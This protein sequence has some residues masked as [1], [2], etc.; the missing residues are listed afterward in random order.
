[1]DNG[2]SSNNDINQQINVENRTFK[3][4]SCNNLVNVTK[5]VGVASS[6]VNDYSN[7]LR[8]LNHD[9]F[10]S[11]L[12]SSQT[13]MKLSMFIECMST[14]TDNKFSTHA[15]EIAQKIGS[16]RNSTFEKCDPQIQKTLQNWIC[17]PHGLISSQVKQSLKIILKL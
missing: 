15:A 4:N 5:V 14:E 10:L 11:T 3:I 13:A 16:M 8:Q 1:M 2:F 6:T 9:M 17:S 7:R 12:N